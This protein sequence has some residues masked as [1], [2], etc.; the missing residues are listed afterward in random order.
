MSFLHTH[1]SNE[2][3]LKAAVVGSIWGANEIIIGS[4]L[5]NI[6]MPLTGTVLAMIGVVL[7][8]ATHRIWKENGIIWRAGLICAIMKSVSPSAIILLPMMGILT[9]AVLLEISVRLFGKNLPAYLIGGALAVLSTLFYRIVGFILYYGFNIVELFVNIYRFAV[10]QLRIEFFGPW[11]L[12]ILLVIIYAALGLFAGFA[13]YRIGGR[14]LMK[15]ITAEV[16]PST[17]PFDGSFLSIDPKQKYSKYL[18]MIH[19]FILVLGLIAFGRFPF[20]ISLIAM[21][22]YAAFCIPLYRHTMKRLAKPFI[23]IQLLIV[24]L[25]ASVFLGSPEPGDTFN[26][27]GLM[28]GLYMNLRAVFVIMS[29]TALGI[30]LRN[31]FIR[32]VIL[33]RRY[34]RF[35]LSM[36]LAF[37]ILPA[38]LERLTKP[39]EFLRNPFQS[40]QSLVSQAQTLLDTV[41]KKTIAPPDIFFIS[42]EVGQGKTTYA[43]QVTEQLRVKNIRVMGFLAEGQWADNRKTGFKLRNIHNGESVELCRDTPVEGWE[44]LARFY[45]NPLAVQTGERWLFSGDNESNITVIDEIGRFE[46]EGRLWAHALDQLIQEKHILILVVRKKFI[47]SIINKWHIKKVHILD[48]G[49]VSADDSARFIAH[50]VAHRKA[51][52]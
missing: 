35:Y 17:R 32:G 41:N 46:A 48:I 51:Q 49:S 38:T 4:F 3:W 16:S 30:E 45:F 13:G 9:E 29:F 11:E 25:L 42:G 18:A 52:D 19:F 47:Q 44:K 22:V 10:K 34:A 40:F 1:D 28:A 14:A 7:L 15:P 8:V 5:H 36:E 50:A 27:K 24:L 37:E 23:W 6:N 33:N 2:K 26:V 21:V 39:K 31:P 12:V 43:K 20:E